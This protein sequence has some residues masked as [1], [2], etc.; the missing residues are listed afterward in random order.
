MTVGMFM[1]LISAHVWLLPAVSVAS[2]HDVIATPAPA[3][4]KLALSSTPRTRWKAM[5]SP[6]NKD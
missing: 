1:R 2:K 5:K 3:T 4:M 6:D